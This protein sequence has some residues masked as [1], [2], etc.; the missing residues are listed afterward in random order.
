MVSL[1]QTWKNLRIILSVHQKNWI[2]LENICIRKPREIYTG[3][4]MGKKNSQ[5]FT[6]CYNVNVTFPNILLGL[7]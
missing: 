5:M 2:E 1:K 7:L 6:S 4:E 3:D